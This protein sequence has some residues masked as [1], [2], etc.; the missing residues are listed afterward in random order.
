MSRTLLL[1][2]RFRN[3]NR[4][5]NP[6]SY[7]VLFGQGIKPFFQDPILDGNIEDSGTIQ[8]ATSSTVVISASATS[9]DDFFNNMYIKITSGT[10]NGMFRRISDYVGSSKTV[11]VSSDWTAPIANGP[12]AG[13][14][15]EIYRGRDAYSPLHYRGTQSRGEVCYR[16]SL[17]SIILPNDPVVH[18]EPYFLVTFQNIS[19]KQSNLIITNNPNARDSQFIVPVDDEDSSSQYV[20]LRGIYD[21]VTVKFRPDDDLLFELKYPDGTILSFGD[22]TSPD[23][24]SP[25]NQVIAVFEIEPLLNTNELRG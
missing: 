20:M 12:S 21:A 18:S 23:A 16:V 13:D 17:K 2:S 8:S 1:D 4:Y 3:R 15:Y 10:G 11:T 24:P 9:T 7:T 25:L 14:T 19:N 22:T 5:P 6:C